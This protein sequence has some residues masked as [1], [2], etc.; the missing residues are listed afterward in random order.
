MQTAAPGIAAVD[1]FYGDAVA[2]INR[3]DYAR[4]LDLLQTARAHAPQDARVL[5]A[6]GVVYDKLG[7]FDLSQRYYAEAQTADPA[8]RIVAENLAYSKAL[9]GGTAAVALAEVADPVTA[10]PPPRI[11]PAAPAL[12]ATPAPQDRP[13]I[14]LAQAEPVASPISAA[15]TATAPAVHPEPVRIAAAAPVE[16][17]VEPSP[18]R[19][20]DAFRGQAI[21]PLAQPAVASA[22]PASGARPA[23]AEPTFAATAATPVQQARRTTALARRA[24]ISRLVKVAALAPP[25]AAV[26]A[27]RSDARS[28]AVTPRPAATLRA[29][30]RPA[31]KVTTAGLSVNRA[32]VAGHSTVLLG[33]PVLIVYSAAGRRNADHLRAQLTHRG[34]SLTL[35]NRRT[36]AARV[37]TV[38]YDVSNQR[39]ALALARS[40][41]IPVNLERCRFRCSGVTILVG[42][43]NVLRTAAAT[44]APARK[45]S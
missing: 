7:R 33:R 4:A 22:T 31:S 34:W 21:K 11:E 1:L 28:A 18:A 12:A 37:T 20:P 40:L 32:L 45:A 9:Q 24:P 3:R 13:V 44:T 5:N 2:A 39:L 41:R 15:A 36:P 43:Q 23:G 26:A 17:A 8:S 38:R 6:F 42:E 35:A 25:K 16:R 10:A 27:A 14:M 19:L 29:S 30:P